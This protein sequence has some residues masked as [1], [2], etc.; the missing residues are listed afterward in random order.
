MKRLIMAGFAAIGLMA[1][2]AQAEEAG[3]IGVDWVGN[4]IVIEAVHD[5]EVSGIT[6]HLA[7]FDRGMIDR[8][9]KGNW[10]EDPSNSSIACRA[11]GPIVVGDIELDQDG[12]E[13]FKHG[14]SFL[15]KKLVVNRIFDRENNTMIYLSHSRQ[16]TDGSAKMAISTVPFYGV[17]VS[18]DPEFWPDGAPE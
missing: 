14:R 13:V 18:W 12:E 1:G 3:K 4:D 6:C 15:W 17:E 16:V 7:Y 11:T 2:G 8:L 10:F 5:R 9:T